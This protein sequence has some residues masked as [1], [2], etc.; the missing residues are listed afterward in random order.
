MKRTITIDY[1]LENNIEDLEKLG[2][3]RLISI[4]FILDFQELKI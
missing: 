2:E 3:E 1:I 4:I